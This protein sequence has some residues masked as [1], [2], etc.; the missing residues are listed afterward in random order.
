[1]TPPS[2][3]AARNVATSG[4]SLRVSVASGV[5]GFGIYHGGDIETCMRFLDKA[6]AQVRQGLRPAEAAAELVGECLRL[7]R[8]CPGFG[9]RIHTADRVQRGCS[10]WRTSSN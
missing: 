3:L 8:P 5:L 2:T 7:D 1:V 6:L 10:R 4:A 9:H